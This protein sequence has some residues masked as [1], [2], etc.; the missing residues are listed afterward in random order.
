VREFVPG[1]YTFK[2][3]YALQIYAEGTYVVPANGV[4][5]YADA[6]VSAVP[7]AAKGF[8]ELVVSPGLESTKGKQTV[9]LKTTGIFNI[10]VDIKN[11]GKYDLAKFTPYFNGTGPGLADTQATIHLLGW[12]KK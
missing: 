11:C 5:S 6:S 1:Q 10:D 4:T 3:K 7:P 9:L 2:V 12:T 8:D